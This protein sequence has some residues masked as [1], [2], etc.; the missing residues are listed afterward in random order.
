MLYQLP[1]P[2]REAPPRRPSWDPL[3]TIWSARTTQAEA[4]RL[5]AG[6]PHGSYGADPELS[7]GSVATAPGGEPVA[8]EEDDERY[9][10]LSDAVRGLGDGRGVRR[11]TDRDEPSCESD[12]DDTESN[13]ISLSSGVADETASALSVLFGRG[14]SHQRGCASVCRPHKRCRRASRCRE[15][16]CARLAFGAVAFSA[17][18]AIFGG[19]MR[20]GLWAPG[21]GDGI[22][23]SSGH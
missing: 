9:L 8:E 10:S 21:E 13:R 22:S 17:A 5:R 12:D 18:V 11:E 1:A 7:E 16:D 19:L 23:F 14:A 3:R 15:V 2:P 4:Q 6:S 20:S